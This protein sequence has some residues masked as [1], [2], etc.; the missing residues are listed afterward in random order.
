VTVLFTVLGHPD[1]TRRA[2]RDLA[3]EAL[4]AFAGDPGDPAVEDLREM[5]RLAGSEVEVVPVDAG[6]PL[7]TLGAMEDEVDQA[8]DEVV[9]QVNA[10]DNRLTHPAVLCCF[11]QGVTAWFCTDEGSIRLPV[12]RGVDV[13]SMFRAPERRVLAALPDEGNREDVLEGLEAPRDTALGALRDLQGKGLVEAQGTRIRLTD[14]GRYYRRGL[15]RQADA[16]LAAEEREP[17][18]DPG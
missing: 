15:A 8:G 11:R 7:E 9:F 2:R 14:A 1:P 16:D 6:A 12:V 3:Y 13:V 4:V 17:S 10:R 18:R 5:E